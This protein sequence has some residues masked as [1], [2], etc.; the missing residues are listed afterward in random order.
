MNSYVDDSHRE[1]IFREQVRDLYSSVPLTTG[2]AFSGASIMAFL[3]WSLVKPAEQIDVLIWMVSFALLAVVRLGNFFLYSRHENR[4]DEADEPFEPT[5][6]ARIEVL[7]T[8]IYGLLF[9]GFFLLFYDT[10]SYNVFY[11]MQMATFLFC[12]ILASA[13]FLSSHLPSYVA[14]AL[15][16][17]S[18]VFVRLVSEADWMHFSM[19]PVVIVFNMFVFNFVERLNRKFKESI[20]ARLQNLDLIQALVEKKEQAELASL[21][22]SKFIAAAGHDLRQPLHAISICATSLEMHV[23]EAGSQMLN[24]I[25]KS[26]SALDNMFNTLSYIARFD[27]GEISSDTSHFSIREIHEQVSLEFEKS[28]EQKGLSFLINDADLY[29]FTDPDLYGVII[30][31]LLSNAIR[32]TEVGGVHINV[33]H[34]GDTLDIEVSDTGGGIPAEIQSR[35]FSEYYQLNSPERDRTNGLGLGLALV[36][37]LT[38]LLGIEMTLSSNLLDGSCFRLRIPMGHREYTAVSPKQSML[39][40]QLGGAVK[41]MRVLIVDDDAAAL[42]SVESLLTQW[43]CHVICAESESKALQ[44]M[45]KQNYIPDAIITDYRLKKNKTG[46]DVI[47]SVR[48]FCH[49]DQLPALMITGDRGIDFTQ[50]NFPEEGHILYKPVKP[51]SMLAFLRQAVD[52]SDLSVAPELAD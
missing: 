15:G 42:M 13:S 23:D 35:L 12:M 31:N 11:Q 46:I 20:L 33:E 30:R 24:T 50:Q 29:A 34:D 2:L 45:M 4:L 1:E 3:I 47:H 49:Q 5:L 28:A 52:T 43:G 41:G 9:G 18:L 17:V 36:K 21:E 39:N 48:K 10:S 27:S 14:L 26:V 8:A 6:W 51:G 32:F 40:M 7:W 22:K 37:R 19:I 44:L 16:S 38:N 25:G